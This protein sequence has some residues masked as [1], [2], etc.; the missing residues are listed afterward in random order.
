MVNAVDAYPFDA[1]I[2]FGQARALNNVNAVVVEVVRRRIAVP[3]RGGHLGFYVLVQ[4]AAKGHVEQLQAA[5]DAEDRLAQAL[6]RRHQ[7]FVVLVAHLVAAPALVQRRFAVA[8]G[9]DIGA[10]VQH[11]TVQPLRIVVKGDVAALRRAGRT[12]H[13]DNHGARRHQPVGDRLLDIL[14][15]LASEQR[16]GVVGVGK[17]GGQANFQAPGGGHRAPLKSCAKPARLNAR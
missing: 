16:A 15:R 8:A 7:R 17:A 13:H 11:Q 10:T 12:R 2:E 1:G 4:G 5:A 14:Q 9:P 6:E 3:E